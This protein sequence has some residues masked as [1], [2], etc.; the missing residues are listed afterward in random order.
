MLSGVD[1]SV[2]IDG[3]AF[4][5]LLKRYHAELNKLSFQVHKQRVP[6][7]VVI[8]GCHLSGKPGVTRTL[9][10]GLD[11]RGFFIYPNFTAPQSGASRHYLWRFWMHLPEA[12]QIAIYDRS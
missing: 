3:K 10:D 6:V 8:E 2:G 12:G 11:P 1:L 7:V 4:Q 9:T 5:K